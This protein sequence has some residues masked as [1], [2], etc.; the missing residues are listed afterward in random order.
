MV[1]F[2]SVQLLSRVQLFATPWIAAH[3]ASLSITNFWSSPKPMSIES[4]MPSNHLIPL[5][6]PSP[7]ALNL[8]QH[9]G[10][11]KWVSSSHQ[12]DW[13]WSWNSNTLATW[14][15]ELIHLKRPW[16]WERLRAGGEGDDRGWDGWIASLT[17]WTWLWLDSGSWWWTGR[18]G[19]LHFIGSQRVRHDWVTELNWTESLSLCGSQQTVENSS[20]HGTSRPPYLLPEKA[21][22]RT[23]SIS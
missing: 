23:R 5:L 7:P 11:F 20:R 14:C 10:L 16:C 15:K 12:V 6:P 1:Q 9:Q 2:S 21:V 8:S 4:L 17:Q 22:W 18:P 3:Q 13:C 19:M